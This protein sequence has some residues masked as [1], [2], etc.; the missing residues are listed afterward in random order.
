MK[1]P[2]LTIPVATAAV[3]T[4]PSLASAEAPTPCTAAPPP[5]TRTPATG[6]SADE[7]SATATATEM[8]PP[9]SMPMRDM[10]PPIPSRSLLTVRSAAELHAA[11]ANP[12]P[13]P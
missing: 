8:M 9:M 12:T 1:T 3:L 6:W 11:W 2:S 4:S 7:T 5:T 13:M 10:A